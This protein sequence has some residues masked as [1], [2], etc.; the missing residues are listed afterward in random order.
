MDLLLE[1]QEIVTLALIVAVGVIL[2]VQQLKD[3]K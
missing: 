1:Y 3:K 2:I